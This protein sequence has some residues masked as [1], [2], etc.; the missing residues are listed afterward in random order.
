MNP[1]HRRHD[2]SY[3]AM[4]PHMRPHPGY[5]PYY[6]PPMGPMMAP[7]PP[8]Y[9]QNWY[10]YQ[11][12]HIPQPMPPHAPRGAQ[13]YPQ[14][15]PMPLH[16]QPPPMSPQHG[17]Q[18]SPRAMPGPPPPLVHQ[19]SSTAVNTITT[20]VQGSPSPQPSVH[21]VEVIQPTDSSRA[22]SPRTAPILARIT[23]SEASDRPFWPPVSIL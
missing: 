19:T 6:Q 8:P 11:Q 18:A 13:F 21:S 17:G 12:H 1:P 4:P 9:A 10:P 7:Y 16:M 5:Q 2:G 22:S 14:G 20:P 3:V 15:P 23:E